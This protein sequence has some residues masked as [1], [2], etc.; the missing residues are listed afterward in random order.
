MCNVQRAIRTLGVITCSI[1]IYT[2]AAEAQEA[3]VEA[4]MLASLG[5]WNEGDVAAFGAFF[6][7]ESRGFNIDGGLLIRGFNSAALEAALAAGFGINV[8][9]RDV[10]VKVYGNAA[11]AVA[12]L[13]GS[14]SLPGGAIREGTW[15]YSETRVKE[16]DTWKIVQYHISQMTVAVSRPPE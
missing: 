14:I 9:P 11:V 6:G 16:G 10:D 4:A 7:A 13:D 1:I 2:Q 3:E 12:Y 8:Q 5:A 15:R